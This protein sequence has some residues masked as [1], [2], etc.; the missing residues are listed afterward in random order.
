MRFRNAL[1]LKDESSN[2]TD[3][4][5]LSGY[6]DQAHFIRAFKRRIGK[7]PKKWFQAKPTIN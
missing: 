6:Y 7:S 2:L 1:R 3:L 5:Y 4:A